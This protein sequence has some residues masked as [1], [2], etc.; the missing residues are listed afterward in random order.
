MYFWCKAGYMQLCWFFILICFHHS[1]G[2]C[3][4]YCLW[5]NTL[6]LKERAINNYARS[7]DAKWACPWKTISH[8]TNPGYHLF[9]NSPQTKNDFYILLWLEKNQA[10]TNISWHVKMIQNK[11]RCHKSNFTGTQSY[12][13]IYI[14][15][16]AFILQWQSWIVATYHIT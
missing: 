7:V 9:W 11:L 6:G 5:Q 10:K 13:I 1:W 3:I 16:K 4:V 8:G 15:D 2:I 12:E 14:W